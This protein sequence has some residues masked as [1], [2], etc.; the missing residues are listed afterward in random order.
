HQDKCFHSIGFG[1]AYGYG[2]IKIGNL[3]VSKLEYNEDS[4]TFKNVADYKDYLDRFEKAMKVFDPEWRDS[5]QLEELLAIAGGWDKNVGYMSLQDYRD[6]KK[7]KNARSLKPFSKLNPDCF[8]IESEG[9][10]VATESEFAVGQKV[11]AK[12][13]EEGKV[14]IDGKDYLSPL[15]VKKTTNARSLIGKRLKVRINQVSRTGVVTHTSFIS[16]A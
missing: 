12:C 5:V 9:T 14:R 3:Q 13:V 4:Y 16:L 1:K 15:G 7:N 2:K 11:I 10:G 8:K 6:A